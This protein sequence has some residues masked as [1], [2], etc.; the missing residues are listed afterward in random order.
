[1]RN[2]SAIFLVLL[3]F[4]AMLKPVTPLIEYAVNKDYLT[5]VFCINKEKPEMHCEAKCY[6]KKQLIKASEKEHENNKPITINFNDYPIALIQL[7]DTDFMINS[8][9]VK[10][11]GFYLDCYFSDFHY[12]VF[13]PPKG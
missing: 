11:P 7:Y 1:M 3:Y 2:F 13:H 12:E 8:S 9:I 6:L 5:K 4:T 10:M